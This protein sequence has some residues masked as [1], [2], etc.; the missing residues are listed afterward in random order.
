MGTLR[1]ADDIRPV[2]LPVYCSACF[3]QD[4]SKTHIDF[5]AN[6]DRGYGQRDDGQTVVMDDLIICE[7]CIRRAGEMVGMERSEVRDRELSDLRVRADKA[8]RE[9]KQAQRYADNLED[10]FT[11]RPTPIHIDHRKRPRNIHPVEET[12]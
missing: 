1:I 3:A 6:S 10:A 8:E 12:A 2:G 5:D 7:D 4:P 9:A 11:N